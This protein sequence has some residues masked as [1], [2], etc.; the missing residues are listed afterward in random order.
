[1]NIGEQ[2]SLQDPALNSFGYIT[3]K[4]RGSWVVLVVK[5]QHATHTHTGEIWRV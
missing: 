1:M 4:N 3:W 5:N 2:I